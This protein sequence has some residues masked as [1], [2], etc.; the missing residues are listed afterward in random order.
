M[1]KKFTTTL[2]DNLAIEAVELMEKH[3]ITSIPVL[4]NK[5]ELVGAVNM[6]ILLQSGVV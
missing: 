1:I 4:D 5:G 6:R 2:Q 3:K